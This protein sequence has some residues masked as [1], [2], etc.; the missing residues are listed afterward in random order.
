[1]LSA[2]FREAPCPHLIP[3]AHRPVA[4]S[5]PPAASSGETLGADD[6]D[7]DGD[8]GDASAGGPAAPSRGA[9][10]AR[11][12]LRPAA[13]EAGPEELLS[14]EEEDAELAAAEGGA[15]QPAKR[16]ARRP[17]LCPAACC[18]HAVALAARGV[19]GSGGPGAS[20]RANAAGPAQGI[21]SSNPFHVKLQSQLPSLTP[22]ACFSLPAAGRAR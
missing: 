8:E 1:M 7:T 10:P 22:P 12:A 13:D 3:A 4:P 6:S 2:W 11:S 15:E 19:G 14:Y 17:L 5:P 21:F 9:S 18:A 20:T 16:K